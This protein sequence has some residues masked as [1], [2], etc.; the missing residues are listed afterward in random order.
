MIQ[1][2]ISPNKDRLKLSNVVLSTKGLRP[3]S[4]KLME[5]IA[6]NT[7]TVHYYGYELDHNNFKRLAIVQGVFIY[8]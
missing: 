8:L 6:S 2:K 3:E 7:P 4:E 1:Q 5:K